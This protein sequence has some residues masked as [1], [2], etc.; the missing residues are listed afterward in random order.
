L[1]GAGEAP[2]LNDQ[3]PNK[4][5]SQM[6]EMIKTSI[7]LVIRIWLF[8]IVCDLVLGTWSFAIECVF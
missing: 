8:E 4:F 6:L 2:N 1:R 5:K 3:A 7:P